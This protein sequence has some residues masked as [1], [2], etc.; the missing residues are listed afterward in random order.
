M[1]DGW[2]MEARTVHMSPIGHTLGQCKGLHMPELT[3]PHCFLPP[4]YR[5][6]DWG[7]KGTLKVKCTCLQS[8]A[9]TICCLPQNRQV[10]A[11]ASGRPWDNPAG[12]VRRLYIKKR[13]EL[14]WAGWAAGK[15][16]L[17]SAECSTKS[18]PGMLPEDGGCLSRRCP[19]HSVDV[20]ELCSAEEKEAKY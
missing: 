16:L 7:S 9:F 14:G 1:A 10:L 4:F 15:I 12:C 11:Q 19:E 3:L 17:S 13:G 2:G 5:W 6:G 8:L 20:T 18:K